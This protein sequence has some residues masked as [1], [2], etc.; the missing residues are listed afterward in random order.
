MLRCPGTFPSCLIHHFRD[1]KPGRPELQPKPA[2]LCLL[3]SWPGWRKVLARWGSVLELH[4]ALSP[5]LGWMAGPPPSTPFG[6]QTAGLEEASQDPIPASGPQDQKWERRLAVFLIF[7]LSPVLAS[8]VDPRGTGLPQ[9][10][11]GHLSS[12]EEESPLTSAW[13]VYR[14]WGRP[15]LAPPVPSP[16]VRMKSDRQVTSW[17][18]ASR[19]ARNGDPNIPVTLA[20]ITTSAWRK[21]GRKL[22]F[23]E[24]LFYV[25]YFTW[26]S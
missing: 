8:T 23:S 26:C 13:K 18:S 10:P 24:C 7:L 1:K 25:Q 21:G 14:W 20:P 11:S 4:S 15:S 2:P 17:C 12:L 9:A 19:G 3:P 5:G 6:Y 16:K 22:S